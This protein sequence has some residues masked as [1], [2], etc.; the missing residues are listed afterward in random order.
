MG[1]DGRA[2]GGKGNRGSIRPPSLLAPGIVGDG[3][4]AAAAEEDSFFFKPF[5]IE[6]AV[7]P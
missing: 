5:L 6:W 1:W 4:T 3:E 2:R 7:L